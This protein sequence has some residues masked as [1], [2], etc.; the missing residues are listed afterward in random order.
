[1]GRVGR[2]GKE[3][4]AHFDILIFQMKHLSENKQGED[5]ILKREKEKGGA[6]ILLQKKKKK[7]DGK[8]QTYFRK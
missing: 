5:I 6:K 4:P 1:L 7:R 8:L 2:L 3:G